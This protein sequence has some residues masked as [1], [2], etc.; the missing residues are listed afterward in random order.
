M[1]KSK[2][3]ALPTDVKNDLEELLADVIPP[4]LEENDITINRIVDRGLS[5]RKAKKLI[6][7]W[8]K[9]KLVVSIG[10]RRS[11]NGNIVL[12]WRKA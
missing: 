8:E 5:Y 12:A 6:A 1:T 7:Q 9:M 10:S 3:L 2:S 4:A 11:A